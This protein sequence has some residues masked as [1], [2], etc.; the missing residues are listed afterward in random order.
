MNK[1]E[2]KSFQD[3]IDKLEGQLSIY[4]KSLD[5]CAHMVRHLFDEP[6]DVEFGIDT[7]VKAF[8][9]EQFL[10]LVNTIKRI[11]VSIASLRELLEMDAEDES[12]A[13]AQ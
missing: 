7:D 12:S 4:E 8:Q 10:H 5:R 2:K 6:E 3:E 13:E 1:N 11:R 9:C